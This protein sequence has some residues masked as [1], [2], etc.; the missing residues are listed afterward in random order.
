MS[1]PSQTA[2]QRKRLALD[3][4]RQP[5]VKAAGRGAREQQFCASRATGERASASAPTMR[6]VAGLDQRLKQDVDLLVR[7]DALRAS[8]HAVER[9]A[10]ALPRS[11]ARLPHLLISSQVNIRPTSTMRCVPGRHRR[12]VTARAERN[13]AVR[14]RS[15]TG[16]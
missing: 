4:P 2:A 10:A 12:E 1:G 3:E 15:E 14:P 6:P 5:L 9:R 11:D 13:R 16:Q 7:D 8:G